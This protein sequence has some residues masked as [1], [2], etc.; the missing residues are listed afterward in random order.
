MA[1]RDMERS[2]SSPH[3]TPFF[4]CSIPSPCQGA[5]PSKEERGF[6]GTTLLGRHGTPI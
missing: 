6:A 2:G 5:S 4:L 1:K 3:P